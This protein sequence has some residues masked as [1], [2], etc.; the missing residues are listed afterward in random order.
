MEICPVSNA[1]FGYAKNI[2]LN[3]AFYLLHN[4]NIKITLSN[5]NPGI[6]GYS[7]L[8]TDY[9]LTIKYWSLKYK[10]IMKIIKNGIECINDKS[11][12]DYY[13][14]LIK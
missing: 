9:C 14:K 4:D 2:N 10:D 12:V 3:P 13:M 1:L 6:F 7:D 5:D 8:S 11:L